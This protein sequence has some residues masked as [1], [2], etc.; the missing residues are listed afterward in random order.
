[1]REE[2]FFAIKDGITKILELHDFFYQKCTEGISSATNYQRDTQYVTDR[3]ELLSQLL[4]KH[5]EH[6]G[7]RHFS[8]SC[9]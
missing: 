9:D 8:S 7:L 2:Q 3:L 5:V 1:M 6:D 4:I